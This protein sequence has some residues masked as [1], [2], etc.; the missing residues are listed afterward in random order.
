M[1]EPSRAQLETALQGYSD[2]YLGQD[3][4]A[5]KCVKQLS[6]AGQVELQIEL[7]FPAAGY[8]AQLAEA[9]RECLLA[10]AGVQT[11][12]VTV[13]WKITAHESAEALK[14]LAGVKNIIA[15][16]S[17][18]GGVGKSTT[19]VNLALALLAEGATVGIPGRGCVRP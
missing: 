3:L 1:S 2:P 17:G 19:S 4:L 16:A 5:A 10:V 7:G 12:K 18:K 15:V 14:T 13:G 11:V 8:Q 9:L 6:Y